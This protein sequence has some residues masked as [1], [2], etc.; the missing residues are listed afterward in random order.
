MSKIHTLYP[1]VFKTDLM[2]D[3]Y[4]IYELFTNF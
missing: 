1:L 4:I 2:N 3:T